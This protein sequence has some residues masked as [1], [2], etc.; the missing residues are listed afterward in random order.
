MSWCHKENEVKGTGRVKES[1]V[2]AVSGGKGELGMIPL[3]MFLV[4]D[5]SVCP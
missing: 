2:V 3:R 1:S 4:K 5:R